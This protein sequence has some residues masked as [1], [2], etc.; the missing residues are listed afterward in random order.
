VPK[1]KK[2]VEAT[3]A[4]AKLYLA[5]AQEFLEEARAALTDSRFDAAILNAVHAAI[6]AADAATASAAGVRSA[7]AD[8]QRA[9]D[10]DGA[11]DPLGFHGKTRAGGLA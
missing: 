11:L 2:I 8:H 5:K 9:A 1:P 10:L 4:E 3:R 6:S 7:D